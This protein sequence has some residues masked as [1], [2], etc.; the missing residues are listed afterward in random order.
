MSNAIVSNVYRYVIDDVIIQVRSEFE[1][2]GI[3]DA[4]LQELQRSWETKVARS[5][6]ANFGFNND[7]YYEEEGDQS[8]GNDKTTTTHNNTD[9]NTA[10]YSKGY[11]Q[12]GFTTAAN[13]AT[14]ANASVRNPPLSNTL[15]HL[16]Q[17]PISSSPYSL[18]PTHLPSLSPINTHNGGGHY[19][20]MNLQR[21]QPH[22]PDIQL[23]G[24]GRPHIPQNDGV[25]DHTMT[26]QEIDAHL[27]KRIMDTYEEQNDYTPSLS[28][29]ATTCTG[30]SLN[31][32]DL[33]DH[34]KLLMK[35]A[36]AK[37]ALRSSSRIGQLDGEVDDND[38]IN[39]DLDD[40]DD[41]DDDPDG[42]EEVENIILCLYDKVTRTKNKWKCVLRDG[43][44]LVNGRDYLFHRANGDFEW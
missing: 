28:F 36:R 40:P 14:L 16:S 32:D 3:D 12:P 10:V 30:E 8:N 31:I 26:T 21:Q 23:P 13:L 4:V 9:N 2:M 17:P 11:S 7:G 39:S 6:V 18:P 44:M 37:A 19:P 33:P 5:R 20:P 34:I 29:S 41:D 22:L 1:D 25:N 24:G 42:G 35:D 15:P 38:D 27:H 43:I